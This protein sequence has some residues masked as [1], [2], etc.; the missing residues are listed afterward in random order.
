MND[1]DY[2]DACVSAR[3]VDHAR[4]VGTRT[5]GVGDRDRGVRGV[6][7]VGWDARGGERVGERSTAE[8]AV[9]ARTRVDA[10]RGDGGE[11]QEGGGGGERDA[12]EEG[13]VRWRWVRARR[14]GRRW[15]GKD[16]IDSTNERMTSSRLLQE[17]SIRS[18]ARHHA[19]LS[20]V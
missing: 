10:A 1:D 16:W 17:G 14:R 20:T 2:S 19:T 18:A 15:G 6:L 12:G 3:R 4:C 11:V 8:R 7:R 9:R 13:V 5:Q